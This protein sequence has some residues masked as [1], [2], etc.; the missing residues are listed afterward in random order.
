METAET[1]PVNLPLLQWGQ[2][3]LRWGGLSGAF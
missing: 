2:V 3:N 1:I